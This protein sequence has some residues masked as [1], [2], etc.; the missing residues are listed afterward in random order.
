MLSKDDSGV[1]NTTTSNASG[2]VAPPPPRPVA[3][4]STSLG[5]PDLGD[6]A[7]RYPAVA[8]FV[9]SQWF[10][11]GIGLV[12]LANCATMGIQA[13]NV[14]GNALQMEALTDVCEYIFTVVFTCE[15]GLRIFIFGVGPYIPP[16][17][18]A[19]SKQGCIE[20]IA[21][22]RFVAFDFMD[23]CLVVISI[24]SCL[25]PLVQTG[26][27]ENGVLRALTVLRSM[28]LLRLVR[29]V[30][31]VE[32]FHEVWLLLRGLSDSV[33]TLVWTIVVIFFIT[34]IFAVFGVVLI[35]PDVLVKYEEPNADE[36]VKALW[37]FIGGIMQ[38]MYTLIQVL[39]LDSWTSVARPLM[40][41]SPFSWAFFYLYISVAVFVLMNLVTAI[42]VDNALK[43]SQHDEEVK[44]QQKERARNTMLEQ[45]KTLFQMMDL[46]GDDEL[47][48][49][50]FE[51]AFETPEV[52]TKL[53]LLDFGPDD[54]RELFYLLD[55]GDGALSLEEFFSGLTRMEGAATSKD[56]FRIM[57][58]LEMVEKMLRQ[59]A[60]E[61][62]MDLLDI[63]SHTPGCDAK[64][65]QGTLKRRAQAAHQRAANMGAENSEPCSPYSPGLL[66]K[67]NSSPSFRNGNAAPMAAAVPEKPAAAAD[68]LSAVAAIASKLD[69]CIGEMNRRFDRADQRLGA[70]DQVVAA[71]SSE[72]QAIRNSLAAGDG[73][74]STWARAQAPKEIPSCAEAMGLGRSSF[75]P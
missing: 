30:R 1:F 45:F 44:L 8:A 10:E 53:K 52:S 47:T 21:A 14:I 39:T 51:T 40:N 27:E 26:D 66:V 9:Q 74:Q 6:R 16:I 62:Q 34:Y 29:I 70:S 64:P 71:L 72:V 41:Y 5:A 46:D 73:R 56:V 43:H 65:R 28:R 69:G 25:M 11:C 38:M 48:K 19:L 61:V 63:K 75:S 37:P 7:S 49:E 60:F 20:A 59:H 3:R 12:I 23:A 13:E 24:V 22:S 31:K 36:E 18:R 15:L 68:V 57:K 32:A 50:E 2:V 17:P 55:T 67:A 58:M 33:R 42:I 35:S 4:R 54:C